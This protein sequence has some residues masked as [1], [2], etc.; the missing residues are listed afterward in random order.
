MTARATIRLGL[1]IRFAFMTMPSLGSA[2]TAVDP[3][4]TTVTTPPDEVVGPE[5]R[6]R[7]SRGPIRESSSRRRRRIGFD[8]FIV[9]AAIEV[10]MQGYGPG[11]SLST[12]PAAPRRS[13]QRRT[14]RLR[15]PL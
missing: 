8:V 7:S 9:V 10:G 15:V 11:P 13:T 4:L 12:W 2:E 5:C 1:W 6:S 14:S 3:A